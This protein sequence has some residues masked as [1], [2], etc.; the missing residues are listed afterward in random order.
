MQYRWDDFSLDRKGALLT[1]QGHQV[2]VSRKVLDC[3]SHLIEHRDRVVGYDE[4][5]R[6]VWGH[7]TIT[8]HQ[9]SQ[10]ILAARRALGDDGQAQRLIR[11]LPGLGYRWVGLLCEVADT[12]TGLQKQAPDR[13]VPTT[14]VD[15]VAPLP[16]ASPP[17]QTQ[18]AAPISQPQVKATAWLRND[19]LR[20]VAA[21]ALTLVAVASI[22]WQLRKAEPIAT[23]AQPA[24]TIAAEHLARLEE[25][26]WRGKYEEV[27]EGLATLPPVVADSPAARL[28]EIRLDIDRGRFDRAAQK[29]ALQQARAKAAD[30]PVWQAK[31]FATQSFLNGSAGRPGPEVLAP[32]RSAVKLLESTGHAASP[33]AMGGALSARG[34]GLMKTGR[35]ESAAHDLVRA[36]ALLLKAGD[37]HAAVDAA[38]TLARIQMR[39]GRLTDALALMMEIADDCRQSSKPVQE[40]YARNA[41]TKIQVELLDWDG[42]LTSSDRSMELLREVPDSERRTRVVQLRAMVLTGMGRLRE[43]ASLIEEGEAMRDDRYSSIV[44]AT[45][46]LASGHTEQAL[47]AATEASA[48]SR[49]DTNDRLNLES[50][51]G[52]LLLWMIA[53]QDL[54]ANG[55]TMPIPSPA[56]LE[57]LQQ[58]ES[59]IGHIARGRWLW[60]QGKSKDAETQFRLALAESRQNNHL[61]G[62]LRSSEALIELLLQRGDRTAAEQTLAK[63]RA[64]DPERLDRDYRANLLGLRVALALGQRPAIEAAYRRTAALAGERTLPAQLLVA[65]RESRQSLENRKHEEHTASRF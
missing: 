19:K 23:T 34:Y 43:A 56:Q 17:L 13:P 21:L 36:R 14:Q 49:Y 53:A 51:E 30:D 18:A 20:A 40:I 47:A 7:D 54:A 27:R 55:K 26:F 42:A 5:S 1:R 50:K 39:M 65:Y 10:V 52:A 44:P 60:A 46:H 28:L 41:A 64:H 9:L 3:I 63:L 22:V 57:A 16:Q 38:D 59:D 2:D 48:F 61:S 8:H 25:A 12:G 62:I 58:P 11:T 32:A 37:T 29:L 33:Q 35:L 31:L 6:R 24:A 15:A 4:L 45:Y